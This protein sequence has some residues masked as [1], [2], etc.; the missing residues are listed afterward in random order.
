MA[1]RASR[2]QGLTHLDLN[3]PDHAASS[4]RVL[5]ERLADLGLAVNGLAMRYYTNPAYRIGAFTNPD[6]AVRRRRSTSPG[7]ASTRPARPAPT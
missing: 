5:S 1:E 3:Y 6:P 7:A 4:I 2:V